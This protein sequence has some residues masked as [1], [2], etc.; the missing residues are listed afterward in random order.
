M[1]IKTYLKAW[2]DVEEAT[3]TTRNDSHN[4]HNAVDGNSDV[5]AITG[6]VG[7]G[8]DN[9]V[10]WSS[11]IAPAHA[12]FR[13]DS[14]TDC[15]L[16]CWARPNAATGW[17]AIMGRR[18]GST[19]EP[20][21]YTDG[22]G[23]PRVIFYNGGTAWCTWT[24]TSFTTAVWHL[25]IGWWDSTAKTM[26]IQMDNGTPLSQSAG[27][28]NPTVDVTSGVGLG[29][30]QYSNAWFD[31]DGDSYAFGAGGLLTAQDRTDLW[32]GGSGINYAG[33]PV[34]Y[35]SVTDEDVEWLQRAGS[36]SV[37]G[38]TSISETISIIES[39]GLQVGIVVVASEVVQI[40]EGSSV[41]VLGTVSIVD[42]TVE[43]SES[44]IHPTGIVFVVNEEKE[45]L[46]ALSRV[47]SLPGGG[48]PPITSPETPRLPSNPDVKTATM[49][50]VRGLSNKG[51]IIVKT[52]NMEDAAFMDEKTIVA[53]DR[54]L[55][56]I[57]AFLHALN[58]KIGDE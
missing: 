24:T 34:E 46:E 30:H 36:T 3:G 20:S 29:S 17:R 27:V 56:N 35:V 21:L 5:P 1:S 2:W 40:P 28:L 11:L 15:W 52:V 53:I 33:I 44:M 31:G 41:A 50:D 57:H 45:I 10:N 25:L 58:Q 39:I 14:N 26:N 42:E 18:N 4:S 22:S 49:I 55:R 47:L 16:A 23:V 32:N 13:I 48:L 43:F 38:A 37:R 8:I 9:T 6:K 51:Q 7:T 54:D 19:Y 12:D